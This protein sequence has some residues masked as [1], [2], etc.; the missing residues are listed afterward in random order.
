MQKEDSIIR[1]DDK[2]PVVSEHAKERFLKVL[3]QCGLFNKAAR[4]SG[5]TPQQ[6][7]KA[8]AIDK[9]FAMDA[10]V[11]QD[12]YAEVIEEEIHRRAIEGVDKPVYHQGERIDTVK[13][14]SDKLLETLAKAKAKDY[15]PNTESTH[16]SNNVLV[17]NTSSGNVSELLKQGQDAKQ[18]I[19]ESASQTA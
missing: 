15:K 18:V 9:D 4:A 12:D 13:Q 14:Y 17:V 6:V 8:M 5:L 3:S 11:A 16:T 10:E 2:Y 19:D 1:L 7:R